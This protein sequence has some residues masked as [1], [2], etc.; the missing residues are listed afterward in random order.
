MKVTKEIS[1]RDFGMYK[2]L[3]FGVRC[4][5]CVTI[6]YKSIFKII[7]NSQYFNFEKPYIE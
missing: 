3:V 5:I 1:N 6:I 7:L 2:E 4:G